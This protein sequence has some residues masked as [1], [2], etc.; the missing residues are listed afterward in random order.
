MKKT[1]IL[2][3]IAIFLL[4]LVV[5]IGFLPL[6]LL[7]FIVLAVN[8]LFN[9]N[10]NNPVIQE[11]KG[12]SF[13]S[14][15]EVELAYGK[16]DSV[17]VLN[18]TKANEISDIVMSYPERGILVVADREIP[19]NDITGISPKNL[20]IIPYVVDECAVVINTKNPV[21]PIIHLRVGYDMG[22]AQ[23]VAG[24]IYDILKRTEA[25]DLK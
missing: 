25:T 5:N 4:A 13:S 12:R 17:V 22:Y 3:A 24:Q 18:A 9:R 8:Y 15:E 16:P 23:E 2:A 19:I 20:A 21:S 10:E 7:P 11:M 14:V 1:T 6:L